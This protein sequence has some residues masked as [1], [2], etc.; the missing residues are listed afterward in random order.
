MSFPDVYAMMRSNLTN[1]HSLDDH[2]QKIN[3]T[4]YRGPIQIDEDAD[5]YFGYY[6]EK[7]EPIDE[8]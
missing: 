5:I 8:E 2:N 7:D 3:S 6:W 1:Y 4:N